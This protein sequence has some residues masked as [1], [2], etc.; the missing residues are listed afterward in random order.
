MKKLLLFTAGLFFGLTL[1]AVDYTAWP[2]LEDGFSI[3]PIVTDSTK[4]KEKKTIV[5]RSERNGKKK[6]VKIEMEVE[7]GK[8]TTTVF[9]D[10]K[11]LAPDSEEYKAVMKDADIQIVDGED[12]EDDEVIVIKDEKRKV[13]KIRKKKG[14]GETTEKHIRIIKKKKGEHDEDIIIKNGGDHHEESFDKIKTALIAR[15]VI[16]R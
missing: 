10:G 2:F 14:K 3:M 9:L 11:K 13:K 8:K 6:E 4:P 16:E 15:R 12:F 7:N 5:Q 1:Q